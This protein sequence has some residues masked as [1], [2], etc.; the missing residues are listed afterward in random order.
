MQEQR[1]RQPLTEEEQKVILVE[2]VKKFGRM[3]WFRDAT[4]WN[5]SPTTGEPTLEFKVNY[6]PLFER[7]QVLEFAQNVQLHEKFT[8]VDRNGNPVE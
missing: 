4:V 7:K 5:A 3:E 2:V 8:I 6:L 1:A